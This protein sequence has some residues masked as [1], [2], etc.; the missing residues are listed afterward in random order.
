[1]AR[2]FLPWG[3]TPL[4]SLRL[5]GEAGGIAMKQVAGVVEANQWRHR[6]PPWWLRFLLLSVIGCLIWWSYSFLTR[7]IRARNRELERLNRQL[8]A[9]IA[10]RQSAE[11]RLR[12]AHEHLERRVAERTAELMTANAVLRCEIQERR[13]AEEALKER[14][15]LEDLIAAIATDFVRL[16]AEQ[17]D[18]HINQALAALG[19]FAQVDRSYVFV[20][21]LDGARMSCTHEWV[22]EG[23][24]PEIEN[25]RAL[26]VDDFPW[27]MEQLRAQQNIYIPCVDAL[28]PEAAAEKEILQAQSIQ[29]LIV[30]PMISAGE[31]LGFLGFDSVRCQREWP[32]SFIPLL[33]ISGEIIANAIARNRVEEKIRR[34]EEL[35]RAIVEGTQAFLMSV[36]VRGRITYANDAAVRAL[37]FAHAEEVLGQRYL[38]FVHPEDRERVAKAYKEQVL[39]GQRSLFMEFRTVGKYG[40]VLLFSFM[41]NPMIDGEQVVGQNGVG[42]DITAR[43]VAEETLAASLREKEMLLKEIHHRVKNNMQVVCSLLNLQCDRLSSPEAVQALRDSQNRVKSMALIHE[44]LYRSASLSRIDFGEYLHS[45]VDGLMRSY[46]TN[47]DVNVQVTAEN[48]E[49]GIDDAIPCGLL[50]NELISNALKHA[51]PDGRGGVIRVSFRLQGDRYALDVADDGVGLPAELDFRATKSLG[52]QLVTTLVDQIDGHIELH[53]DSPGTHFSISFPAN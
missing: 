38:R 32:E 41:S 3:E 4:P 6:P 51:F 14:L 19:A 53:R 9:E 50:V 18:P 44:K 2:R 1:G 47:G 46:A 29:S 28:P 37:G 52:L 15:A 49:M 31:L 11:R 43:K 25:L 21:S 8:S 45:L 35:F 10:E 34:T 33:R 13:K 20:F 40:N 39:T 22:A 48:A 5:S 16:R 7:T 36:D 42:Q 24:H 12:E 17:V 26:S 30:V 23:I 27:W